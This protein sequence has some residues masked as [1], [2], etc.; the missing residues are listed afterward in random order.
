MMNPVR[1]VAATVGCLSMSSRIT[2]A[3]SDRRAS[4]SRSHEK[5][6][7]QSSPW[8]SGPPLFAKGNNDRQHR[9]SYAW[10]TPD[11]DG[12]IWETS[13]SGAAVMYFAAVLPTADLSG[14]PGRVEGGP[15]G[16]S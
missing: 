3:P 11:D 14:T 2:V 1:F 5:A 16:G 7:S 4:G 13:G 10:R 9:T 8:L 12:P 15:D 6:A